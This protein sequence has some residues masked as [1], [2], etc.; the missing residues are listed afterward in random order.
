MSNS[1]WGAVWKKSLSEASAP[2]K[3]AAALSDSSAALASREFTT[4]SGRR[5]LA[6]RRILLLAQLAP[7]RLRQNQ[8]RVSPKRIPGSGAG[9]RRT[10]RSSAPVAIPAHLVVDL[11]AHRRGHAQ[12]AL[13]IDGCRSAF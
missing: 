8:P 9:R 6:G 5:D 4:N 13:R 11:E 12:H 1:S 7:K 10:G 3:A 2:I